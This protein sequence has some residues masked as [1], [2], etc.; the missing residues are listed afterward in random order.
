[1]RVLDESC[2]I[3][4]EQLLQKIKKQDEELKKQ[5]EQ[6]KKLQVANE[7]RPTKP[8]APTK[9]NSAGFEICLN[10]CKHCDV[11]GIKLNYYF[12]IT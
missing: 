6:M 1:M 5:N 10:N 8:I 11:C 9:Q 3:N 12:V 4:I 2:K 7:S